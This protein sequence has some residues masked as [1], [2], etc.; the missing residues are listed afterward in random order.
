MVA[1]YVANVQGV[2]TH[3]VSD[4]AGI[5]IAPL[6]LGLPATYTA[7]NLV[8][9]A[10]S[11]VNTYLGGAGPISA[12]NLFSPLGR[13]A[14]RA[15]ECKYVADAMSGA[16]DAGNS[17]LDALTLVSA[18]DFHPSDPNV[19]APYN[20]AYGY[21]YVQIPRKR[22][23][24]G[25]GLAEAPRGA[26]GHWINIEDQKIA[27]YQCVVPSTWNACPKGAN[28]TDRGPAESVLIGVP[29]CTG[30]PATGNNLNDAILNAARMLHPYDFCIACAVHIV[31]PEGKELA[32]FKMDSD[33]KI[34][35]YPVD[36]E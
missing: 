20:V 9:V 17:W 3:T 31:T 35:K 22:T 34:T 19:A 30:N 26:L 12:A 10:I 11:A 27:N 2:N 23:L 4:T 25:T 1:S 16:V 6:G 8:D 14:A 32:K 21:Q 36:S 15:L 13:H 28:P 33:G 24:F 18:T 29:A 5:G 7:K